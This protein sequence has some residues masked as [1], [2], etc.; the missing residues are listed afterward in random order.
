MP[1]LPKHPGSGKESPGELNEPEAKGPAS[2]GP[3]TFSQR[4]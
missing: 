2:A 1:R 4:Q 3:E